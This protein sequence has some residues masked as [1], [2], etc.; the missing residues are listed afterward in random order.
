MLWNVLPY[1]VFHQEKIGVVIV[2]LQFANIPQ[3]GSR[4]QCQLKQK[5]LHE[6]FDVYSTFMLKKKNM[7]MRS[8]SENGAMAHQRL[9]A[10]G[11]WWFATFDAVLYPN[12]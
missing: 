8:Q 12:L 11:Q 10:L 9:R 7:Q 3:L 2:N 5:D 6:T 4:F 1:A